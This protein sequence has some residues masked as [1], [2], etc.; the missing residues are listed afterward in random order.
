MDKICVGHGDKEVLLDGDG[1]KEYRSLVGKMNWIVQGTR[2]DWAFELV[3]LSTRFKRATRGDLTRVQKVRRKI[4]E[5]HSIIVF[6]QLGN[7]SQWQLVV[8][9]DD[10]HANLSNGVSSS[11][12]YVLF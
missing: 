6:P 11:M 2:P 10:A 1:L 9:T 7:V 4:Q 5:Y 3:E 12:A 8:F